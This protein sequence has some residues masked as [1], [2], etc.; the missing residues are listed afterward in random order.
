[1]PDDGRLRRFQTT[2]RV[3]SVAELGDDD[4]GPLQD[5]PGKWESR[6]SGWNMI[7]LPF[8]RTQPNALNYRL[9]LNQYD[10]TLNFTF[11]DK[12]VPNR[13][14]DDTQTQQTDQF[15]VTLDYEQV[16]HQVAVIDRP[17]SNVAGAP[18]L[19][20]HHEPGLFLNMVNLATDGIDVARLAS[21]PHG[22]SALALGTNSEVAGV[23][24][25]PPVNG[26]P[27]GVNQDLAKPYLEPYQH[28]HANPF[29]GTV[30]DPG[31]PGFDPVE[32][33]LLL[34]LAN[35]G[36]NVQATTVL[37][38]DTTTQSGGISNIPFIEKQ[39]D[40]AAMKSTFWIQKLGGDSPTFRLQ[41]L[42][43]VNLEFFPRL[44]GLP[45]RII[46]PHVSINTLNKVSDTPDVA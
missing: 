19:A 12:G 15:I 46:W 26:L 5:L 33:H 31:F 1:M 3:I 37:E 11:V 7:A 30:T 38:L 16:I 43:I 24:Q 27:I 2:E 10:E 35:Q 20:I 23:A 34:T 14:V 21:I 8:A 39:A 41:Y 13:G 45:G 9:L 42:Q 28:F 32:P 18:G 36:V 17:P 4:L 40:A 25:I 29:V 22:N 6:G 44:D